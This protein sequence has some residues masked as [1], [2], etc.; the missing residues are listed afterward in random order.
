MSGVEGNSPRVL[1]GDLK[2]A[3]LSRERMA[4]FPAFPARR[5]ENLPPARHKISAHEHNKENYVAEGGYGSFIGT[6]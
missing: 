5:R 6:P 4:P 1:L 2:E 3:I